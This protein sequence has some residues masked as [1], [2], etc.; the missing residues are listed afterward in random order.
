MK[1]DW[2]AYLDGSLDTESKAQAER[3]LREN[4]AA[5]KELE[6]LQA[7]VGCIRSACLAESVPLERLN[8]LVPETLA[9]ARARPRFFPRLAIGFAAAAVLAIAFFR[10]VGQGTS[11]LPKD[12]ITDDPVAAA[13]WASTRLAMNVPPIDLGSDAPIFYAH[14][15]GDRCCFD[16]KLD[17]KTYHVNIERRSGAVKVGREVKLSSGDTA[18]VDRGVRWVQGRYEMFIVGPETSVSLDLANRT[19]LQLERT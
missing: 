17:G 15:Y 13:Q 5:N 6:G 9:P 10:F 11:A 16:Y 3:E 8:Q 12:L 18:F 7:F 4:P 14:G 2:Q 1:I 19:S